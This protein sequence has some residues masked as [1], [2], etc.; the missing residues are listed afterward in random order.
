MD[1]LEPKTY[2]SLWSIIS[3]ILHDWVPHTPLTIISITLFILFPFI[4]KDKK[5]ALILCFTFIVPVLGLFFFCKMF[6]IA[7]FITSRYFVN[8]LP[9]F[10]ISL[11]LSLEALEDK[12]EPL[13]KY[14][15]FRLLFV[16][17]FI[18]SNL[19]ILPLYYR[20][21]KQD[22]R[23][24][25]NY[26]KVHLKPGDKIL[27]MDMFYTPGVLY[28][29]GVYPKDRHYTIPYSKVSDKEIEFRTSFIFRGNIY[30]IY[31][32]TNCCARYLADRSRLWFVAGRKTA[33]IIKRD[34]P[35]LLKGYF[36]GSFLNF[37]RF[38]TDASIYLFLW[39]PKSPDEKG[40]DM[41][42]E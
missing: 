35:C 6:G 30:T 14:L 24:L 10:L 1:P 16:F 3:G 38:P 25:V 42:I 32:S 28:Y 9:I 13:K 22:L 27:D 21:E 19:V 7:H 20:Y 31:S 23:G 29:F 41:P 18:A 2:L 37:N 26:L 12:F 34:S 4:A 15:R 36:D 8:F 33:K 11:F 17:L 39:D 5:N 40:I